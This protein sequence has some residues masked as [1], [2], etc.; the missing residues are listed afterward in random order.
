MFFSLLVKFVRILPLLIGRLKLVL[1]LHG[2]KC[3]EREWEEEEE[4]DLPP[5]VRRNLDPKEREKE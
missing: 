4:E 5:L 1:F 2:L 3:I